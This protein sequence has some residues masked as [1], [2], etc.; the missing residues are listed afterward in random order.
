MAARSLWPLDLKSGAL[1]P[2][3]GRVRPSSVRTCG[4]GAAVGRRWGSGGGGS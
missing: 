1:M 3:S 4:G 2:G